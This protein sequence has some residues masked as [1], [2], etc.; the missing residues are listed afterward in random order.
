MKGLDNLIQE[1]KLGDTGY[2]ESQYNAFDAPV[3]V[4]NESF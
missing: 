2:T 3:P 1:V 4:D